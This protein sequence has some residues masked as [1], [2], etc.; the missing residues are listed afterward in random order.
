MKNQ[1]S[2]YTLISLATILLLQ[3]ITLNI[4]SENQKVATIINDL[5]LLGDIRNVDSLAFNTSIISKESALMSSLKN[6][7]RDTIGY[8]SIYELEQWKEYRV[9]PDFVV[10]RIT[11]SSENKLIL[12]AY[13][14]AGTLYYGE[15]WY[16]EYIWIFYRWFKLRHE[17]IGVS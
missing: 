16:N 10:I 4:F 9:N 5:E 14:H 1:L 13:T 3:V 2:K 15:A 7:F 17:N 6:R 8:L 12:K 11:D